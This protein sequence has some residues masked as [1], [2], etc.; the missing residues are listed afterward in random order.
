MKKRKVLGLLAMTMV[1][2]AGLTACSSS[3]IDRQIIE[4]SE[5]NEAVA[6]PEKEKAEEQKSEEDSTMTQ[7]EEVSTENEAEDAISEEELEE[8][9]HTSDASLSQVDHVHQYATQVLKEATCTEDGKMVTSCVSCGYVRESVI[10]ATGHEAGEWK[11]T[12]LPGRL[13]EGT[14]VLNCAKCGEVMGSEAIEPT[15]ASHGS[16]SQKSTP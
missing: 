7:D 14:R 8:A 4:S 1:M 13:T 11:V 15:G 9:L 16:S 12:Q 10:A 2:S 3:D 5:E 6:E